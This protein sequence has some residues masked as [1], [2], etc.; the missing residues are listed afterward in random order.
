MGKQFLASLPISFLPFVRLPMN[1]FRAYSVLTL[2]IGIVSGMLSAAEPEPLN[3]TAAIQMI[4]HYCADC[5]SEDA[6]EADLNLTR[7][8][9]Y[10]AIVSEPELWGK[11]LRRVRS[12]EM[13]PP[14]SEVLSGSD[15]DRLVGWI[16][17][18]LHTAA[19]G[20][21]VSPSAAGLRRLNRNEYAATVRDLLGIHV[22]VA[23]EFP[24]DGAGGE[25][26]D[27]AG[28]TLFLSPLHAEKF[29]DAARTA[30]E[31]AFRD[32]RAR[33]QLITAEP[34]EELSP[35][36]AAK[37][38]LAGFLP[39]AFRRPVSQAELQKYLELFQAVHQEE[40]SFADAIQFVFEAVMLSPNFLFLFEE[41]NETA[42]PM[43]LTDH[44]LASRL[45]YFLWGSMPDD[46]LFQL[47]SNG[48]L[49]SNHVLDEEVARMLKESGKVRS[50]A[51]SFVE[52]W[53]GT[54]A[55]GREFNPDPTVAKR[56]DSELEGGMKYEP[57]FF[58]EELLIKNL[59][60]LKLIDADFTYANRRL[61]RHYRI[62]GEFR[63]Q[64][65]RVE[66]PPASHRGGVLG[67][68]AVLAV[69]SYPHRTSPVL[70]GKWI[71]ETLLGDP[72]PPPPP[73]VPELPEA[74]LG[75]AVLSLR[76]RLEQHRQDATCASCHDR[77]DPLGFGLENYDVLGRWRE[78]LN[79]HPIDAQGELPDG[80]KFN[81]PAELKLAL[82]DRKDQFAR[83][84]T[85]KMLGYALGRG[86][87]DEDDC[88]VDEMVDQLK[89]HDYSTHTL[90][91]GIVKSV[92]FRYKQGTDPAAAAVQA[93]AKLV[94]PE[95]ES[96]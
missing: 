41:P 19:C 22:N 7:F 13:P 67:M 71:L 30:L 43:L 45:S 6:A 33:E 9:S 56:Y 60:L 31:H 38:V 49:N 53:L 86:L 3:P 88:V 25:G 18:S 37:K 96:E 51:E 61:A 89:K 87:S 81:G 55:L 2:S 20:D 93:E 66:L 64:P 52:Q 70:R 84:L 50:F 36:A 47:A 73:D 78:K 85:A 10:E 11:V 23:L 90:V 5:H 57:V 75:G 40:R 28:E 82:L 26:F 54:R 35:D 77:M 39:R 94:V 32:Q 92:P 42:K 91:L 8:S 46:R 69:S 15:R 79:G 74:E 21:G 76:D 14:D 24:A 1:W 68:A 12:G 17:T 34:N 62:Q 44:E 58:F 95:Q 65:R 72:P 27:N 63:E 4:S 80:T 59:S 16:Q 48:E 83:H 29:L